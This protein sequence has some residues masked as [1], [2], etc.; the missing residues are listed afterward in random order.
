M[1]APLHVVLPGAADAPARFR[2]A[3]AAWLLRVCRRG[4]P[5]AT[6]EDV[7]FAVS[8]TVSNCVDHA[9]CGRPGPVTVTITAAPVEPGAQRL[10]M[11]VADR[12]RWREPP[13]DPGLRG[14]GLAMTRSIVDLMDVVPRATG[15]TVTMQHTLRCPA[16]RSCA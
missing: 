6:C 12:G 3:V 13:A 2:R 11:V 9:Y 10:T 16:A 5:C 4:S 8:E 14:R 1:T 7:V 15:T